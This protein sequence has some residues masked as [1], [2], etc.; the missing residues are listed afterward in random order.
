M[1]FDKGDRLYKQAKKYLVKGNSAN[2]RWNST[3]GRPMYFTHGKGAY[4]YDVDGNEFIDMCCSHGASLLGHGH[5]VIDNAV[6]MA[7][8]LGVMCSGE[9]QY[10][11]ELAQK[12]CS[13]IP[14]AE[15]VRYTCSGTEAVI[16]TVRLARK[17]TGKNKIIKFVGHF[18]G[19]QDYVLPIEGGIKF[20][21]IDCLDC[22]I[23][24]DVAAVILEPIN[25]NSGVITPDKKYLEYLR[26]V[27]KNKGILLIF[28]ETLSALKTGPSCAQGYFNIVPDLCILGKSIAG[29]MP[30]S[31]ICGKKEIMSCIEQSGTYAGHLIPVIA[32]NAVLNEVVKPY[33]YKQIHDIADSL[34]KGFTDIFYRTPVHFTG[35]GARFGLSF[36]TKE[37]GFKFFELMLNQGVYFHDNGGLSGHHGFSIAHSLSDVYKILNRTEYAVSRLCNYI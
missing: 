2:A 12:I 33:F 16:Q 15:L 25:Y 26:Q 10:Q 30:L 36:K 21:D 7:L 32:A 1:K 13:L 37:I 29:G 34:Y 5:P 17:F 24:N 9:T 18:H 19:L 22:A 23:D 28:D 4:L 31:V 27:T 35:L 14:C 11:S 6:N 20:N 3:L 8:D